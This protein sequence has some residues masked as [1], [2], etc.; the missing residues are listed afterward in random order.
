MI[1]N[2]SDSTENMV[3]LSLSSNEV[4]KVRFPFEFELRIIYTLH[5]SILNVKYHL[6]NKG[7]DIMPFSIG[8]H[9]AFNLPK[10]FENYSLQFET[11]ENLT[12]YQLDN[13]LLSEKTKQIEPILFLKMML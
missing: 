2:L 1:F 9:P 11:D 12:S 6:I 8:G 5:F 13:D 3:I 4:T 7:F 10:K